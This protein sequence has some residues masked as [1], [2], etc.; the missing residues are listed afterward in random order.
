MSVPYVYAPTDEDP[1]IPLEWLDRDGAV[2]DLSSATFSVVLRE[3]STNTA[4]VTKSSGV[5]GASTS[6]NVTITWGTG[7]LASLSGVYELVVT[8]TVGG[9]ARTFRKSSLPLVEV[10]A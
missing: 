10:R 4:A 3:R 2:I 5:T 7:E 8:A 6:P 1:S 9:R